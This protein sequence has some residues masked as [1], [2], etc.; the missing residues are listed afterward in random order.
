MADARDVSLAA[1]WRTAGGATARLAGS[2]GAGFPATEPLDFQAE[3]RVLVRQRVIRASQ[4][5]HSAGE[6]LERVIAGTAASFELPNLALQTIDVRIRRVRPV[7]E[8]PSY[9]RENASSPADRHCCSLTER[10]ET[11][12]IL[13]HG[14]DSALPMPRQ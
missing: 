8:S 2:R 4:Q 13:A 1:D 7:T 3:D 12:G 14:S 6:V 11:R 9:S 5:D 10:G